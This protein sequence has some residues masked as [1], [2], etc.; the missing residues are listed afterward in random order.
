MVHFMC[1]LD[2]AKGHPDSWQQIMSR[3]VYEGV[4]TRGGPLVR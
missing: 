4:S 2:Q 1:Q 3:G